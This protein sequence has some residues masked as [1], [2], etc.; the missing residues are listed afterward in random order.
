MAENTKIGWAHHTL[1]PWQGCSKVSLGCKYC[2]AEGQDVRFSLGRH[3]GPRAARLFANDVYMAKPLAWNR[4]AERAGERRRVFCMSMGDFFELHEDPPIVARQCLYRHRVFEMIGKTPWLDWLLLTK[5]PENVQGMVPDSRWRE[6]FPSNVWLG[7]SIENQDAAEARLPILL[8]LDEQFCGVRPFLSCEPLLGPLDLAAAAPSYM[9]PMI[10][11]WVIVGSES[12]SRA[13]PAQLDWFRSL[14]D[15]CKRM[16]VPYF[17]KQWLE[18]GTRA[19]V[20]LP[21]L[22]GRQ[23]ADIPPT[24]AAVASGGVS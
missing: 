19:K 7:V 4:K 18:P 17:F 24:C 22:D 12:G 8:D 16:G 20:E 3:W 1:N 5:R 23:W 2:Y 13:R 10:L 15:Q 21:V 11:H 14:R 6:R 9:L